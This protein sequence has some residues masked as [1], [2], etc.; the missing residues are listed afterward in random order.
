MR[1]GGIVTSFDPAISHP[2]SPP[3]PYDVCRFAHSPSQSDE[4]IFWTAQGASSRHRLLRHET[5]HRGHGSGSQATVGG[6]CCQSWC[7]GGAGPVRAVI[8]RLG[9][10]A[11]RVH[12][13]RPRVRTPGTYNVPLIYVET[14]PTRRVFCSSS[15]HHHHELM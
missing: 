6:C 10:G 9:A 14:R 3:N 8:Q 11:G 7:C 15:T 5:L 1:C 4:E 13:L 12:R 2:P